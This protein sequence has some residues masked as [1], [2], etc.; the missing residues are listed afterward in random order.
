MP[1]IRSPIAE[2][3]GVGK[4]YGGGP[5]T[6]RGGWAVRD[7]NFKLWPG[8]IVGLLGPNRAGK[9][10]AAKLLLS[11]C[12]A[13]EGRI[14]RFGRPAAERSTLGRVG[15]VHENPAFPLDLTA[16]GLLH[17]YGAISGLSRASRKARISPLLERVRLQDRANEPIGRFSK[18]MIQRL[19]LAQALLNEPSLLVLD[20]PTEGLDIEGRLLVR[21][22]LNEAR[23]KGRSVLLITHALQDLEAVCERVIVVNEGRLAFE[24][25][26][27]DLTS[28]PLT[29]ERERLPLARTVAPLFLSQAR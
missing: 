8:E 27:N 14:Q 11:L 6:P 9:T 3:D 17:Y 20:E 23:G 2:F 26:L 25:A 10:T 15:Y 13:T 24:G 5:E 19:G 4:H 12:K 29:R 21:D 16:E 18:G 7:I 1:D 22:L 28:D